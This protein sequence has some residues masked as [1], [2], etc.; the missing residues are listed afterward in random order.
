MI[1]FKTLTFLRICNHKNSN[2]IAEFLRNFSPNPRS[3]LWLAILNSN[4]RVNLSAS[5][6]ILPTFFILPPSVESMVYL[7]CKSII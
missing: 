6:Y 3:F 2:L 4:W 7:D 5:Y 1:G